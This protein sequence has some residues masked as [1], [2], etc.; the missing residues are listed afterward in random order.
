M[1]NLL[2]FYLCY[3]F[4]NHKSDALP[5]DSKS[6]MLAHDGDFSSDQSPMGVI[7]FHI[8]FEMS[9]D[10]DPCNL[11]FHVARISEGIVQEPAGYRSI[12]KSFN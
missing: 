12:A 10:L 1:T 9:I 8:E 5:L 11:S 7:C 2:L 3:F 4:F 6:F